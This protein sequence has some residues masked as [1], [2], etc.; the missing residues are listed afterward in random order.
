MFLKSKISAGFSSCFPFKI[1]INSLKFSTQI[2]SIH[3][4]I[5][6]SIKFS[7]GINI[8]LNHFSFAQI[9]D[10]KTPFIFLNFQSRESSQIKIDFSIKSFF[11]SFSCKS[12][13]IAIGKSKLDPDF[14]I[15]AG[16][17][18]TTILVIGSLVPLDFIA[19]R[20]LSL[21]SLTHWSGSQTISKYGIPLFISTSTSIKSE[22]NQFTAIEFIL[23]IIY[24]WIY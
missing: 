12:I 13:Q 20:S 7:F 8:R 10:G 14:L 1:S 2:T 18:F 17:I 9:V 24:F 21:A 5:E 6:A 19:E 3:G 11:I 23:L 16:A 15:S 22:F 4:I